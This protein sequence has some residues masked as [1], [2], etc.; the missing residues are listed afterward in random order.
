[1][2]AQKRH[3]IYTGACALS[4]AD[5]AES[6][7]WREACGHRAPQEPKKGGGAG[8][9][10]PKSSRRAARGSGRGN[11]VPRGRGRSRS[12]VWGPG[13][14]QRLDEADAPGSL[15]R[16]LP[17][18]KLRRRSPVEPPSFSGSRQTTTKKPQGSSVAALGSPAA[19]GPRPSWW[20]GRAGVGGSGAG[21]RR[22]PGGP[23]RYAGRRLPRPAGRR[24]R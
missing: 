7:R 23:R 6:G 24:G 15:T 4:L 18:S 10:P 21:A 17:H 20:G 13:R 16:T 12:S 22:R 11:K 2:M 9:E 8:T 19:A 3:Y 5:G 1:M 14:H